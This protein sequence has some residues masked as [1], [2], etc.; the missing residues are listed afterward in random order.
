MRE[1]YTIHTTDRVLSVAGL[2]DDL[3]DMLDNGITHIKF[4]R[5][6]TMEIARS[7]FIDRLNGFIILHRRTDD[8]YVTHVTDKQGNLYWGHYFGSDDEAFTEAANDFQNRINEYVPKQDIYK[9]KGYED[10]DHY[11]RNL[12]EEHCVDLEQVIM[13]SDLLG[14][15]EDFDGLVTTIE[16]MSQQV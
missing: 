14:P 1:P 11:L 10:R 3:G 4:E 13:M 2:I 9:E 5:G 6:K 8:A 15:N 7:K 16:D 12:S